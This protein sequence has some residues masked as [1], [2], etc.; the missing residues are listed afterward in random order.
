MASRFKEKR[1]LPEL[2]LSKTIRLLQYRFLSKDH[3]WS[4]TWSKVHL[5]DQLVILETVLNWSFQ[6]TVIRHRNYHNSD[7]GYL[8]HSK[9]RRIAILI[10]RRLV[11]ELVICLHEKETL[12][13]KNSDFHQVRKRKKNIFNWFV[14]TIKANAPSDLDSVTKSQWW[15]YIDPS[16]WSRE[17]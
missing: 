2:P 6:I 14:I 15:L 5:R 7:I 13:G 1:R 17:D 16:T 3:R 11:N 10:I 12:Q 9:N 8:S 4:C